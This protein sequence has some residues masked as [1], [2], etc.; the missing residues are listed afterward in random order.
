MTYTTRAYTAALT[1]WQTVWL[2]VWW[3]WAEAMRGQ[4]N[5]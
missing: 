1:Y 3:D 2:V 5:E 4:G